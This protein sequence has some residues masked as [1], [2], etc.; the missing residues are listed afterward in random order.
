LTAKL[1]DINTLQE[2]FIALRALSGFTQTIVDG[3]QFTLNNV[4]MGYDWIEVTVEV[5]SNRQTLMKRYNVTEPR[6]FDYVLAYIENEKGKLGEW[7]S[8]KDVAPL[9]E[10]FGE[11]VI[12]DGD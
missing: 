7:I 8:Y 6:T 12:L 2:T 9:N 10:Y 3:W 11:V 5:I 4:I 1:N